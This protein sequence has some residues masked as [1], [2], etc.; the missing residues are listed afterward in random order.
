MLRSELRLG[1]DR[2]CDLVHQCT[3]SSSSSA[4][5][6]ALSFD[7]PN[8]L[9]SMAK[10]ILV[11]GGAGY[12]GSHTVLQLLLGGFKTIVVDNLDNSS[13]V[14]INRIRELAREFSKNLSF[15]KMDLWD[16]A[17][18]DN[19]F[20]STP[21]DVVIHF[22]GLK[23]VGE[24]VQKPLLYYN[25]NLIGTIT[26]LE[27]MAAHGCKKLVFSSLA[28]VYG[29]LK[30]VPC[31]EDFPLAAANPY[32]RTKLFIEEIA[33][34]IYRLDSDWKIILLRY[35]NPVGAHPSGLIG[36]DPRGIPNNLMPFVQQVAVGKRPAVTVITHVN[37]L[38]KL[39]LQSSSFESSSFKSFIYKTWGTTLCTIYWASTGPHEKYF[40]DLAHYLCTEERSLR[41]STSYK[42]SGDSNSTENTAR[43]NLYEYWKH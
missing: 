6:T 27:V 1:E 31:T 5:C 39:H 8:S 24:S 22:A 25:N 20:C 34:D 10:C 43:R 7:N 18:L 2:C 32:G 13:E 35:F 19:L 16:K 40:G 17:G 21:F 11:T 29:W 36:E 23:A 37:Q 4:S 26:L 41:I 33:R 30:V 14:A 42:Y 12:I 28:T 15:H 9:A 38:R 3:T